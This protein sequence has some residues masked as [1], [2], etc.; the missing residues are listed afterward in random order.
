MIRHRDV[1]VSLQKKQRGAV[2]HMFPDLARGIPS[3]VVVDPDLV[4]AG[5]AQELLREFA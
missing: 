4:P 5:A 3:H 1:A 2:L